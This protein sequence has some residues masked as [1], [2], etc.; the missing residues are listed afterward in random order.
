M[1]KRKQNSIFEL[2][3]KSIYF[4]SSH[5]NRNNLPFFV[6]LVTNVLFYI[7]LSYSFV[8]ITLHSNHIQPLECQQKK[9]YEE[10]KELFIQHVF[11]SIE[12][13]NFQFSCTSTAY[14]RIKKNS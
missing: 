11:G 10:Q 8:K 7:G 2:E 9:N 3:L 4:L 12:Y 14:K 5:N 6:R 13:S 1:H